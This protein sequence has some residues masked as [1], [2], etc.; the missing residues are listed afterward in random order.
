[1]IER[2]IDGGIELDVEVETFPI[3]GAFTIARGSRTETRVV[4]V[5]LHSRHAIGRGECVPYGHYGE[6]PASV[7]A[8]IESVRTAIAGGAGRSELLALL[9]AGAARNG[10]DAA[11]WDLEARI[12][13]MSA[14]H[15]AGLPGLLEARTVRTISLDTPETMATEA[16]K[17]PQFEMLKLKLGPGDFVERVEAVRAARPE[18]RLVVDANESW[19]PNEVGPALAALAELGVE[20]VEQPLRP[21]ED[22]VLEGLRRAVPVC[23][24]ESFHTTA[25]LERIAGRYDAVNVKLD[26]TGGLT[27]ALEVARAARER[28]LELMVGCMLGTSLSMAPALLVAQGV[29]W[30][31]LD[32]PYLLARDREPGLLLQ[33]DGVI[34]PN[35]D[36]WGG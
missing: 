14:A 12:S 18:V 2:G 11:L 23:A 34:R 32:G 24:D 13:G 28:G 26:K 15:R 17:L 3:R 9:P 4:T 35:P 31:D 25:D 30:V 16:A 19:S 22:A 7:V 10:I 5:T 1:M 29:K 20:L 21:Q 8:Q 36:L 33:D 27:H 6:S